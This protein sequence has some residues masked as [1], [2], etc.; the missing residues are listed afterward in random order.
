MD[1]QLFQV[2]SVVILSV[3]YAIMWFT[4]DPTERRGLLVKI[5]MI[6]LGAW[7]AEDTAIMRYRFYSYP[8][9]W[10]LKL[11]EVPALVIAIWPVVVLS[12]RA[13]VLRLWPGLSGLRLA[14]AVGAAVTIDA[15]LIETIAADA[16]LWRWAEGGYLGVPLI[17]ML[18]WGAYAASIVW[19]MDFRPR[20][21]AL[22]AWTAP[23][24]ALGGTHLLLVA[25]WWG[26]FRFVARGPLPTELVWGAAGALLLLAVVIVRRRQP[27]RLVSASLA[28]TRML[29]ASVFVVLLAHSESPNR[30]ALWVHLAAV[31]APYLATVE[32]RSFGS[33]S[34]LPPG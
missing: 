28:I 4:T 19:A 10:W 16:Q 22:P 26:A 23:L 11:H 18:G 32:W 17:G 29:A 13:V 25:M 34:T 5:A 27:D 8:D 30:W 9:W 14:L 15:T 6:A 33:Q 1:L 31:A 2:I 20:G 12:S 3:A 21:F 24:L 7:F